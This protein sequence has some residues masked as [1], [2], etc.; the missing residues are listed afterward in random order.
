MFTAQNKGN[1]A[2]DAVVIRC[3]YENVAAGACD[4][5]NLAKKMPR[6]FD[7]LNYLS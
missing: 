3:R 4:S 5:V 7:V 1:D 6:V 2:G